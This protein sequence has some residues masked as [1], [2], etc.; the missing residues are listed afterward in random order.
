MSD[1]VSIKDLRQ[2][3]QNYIYKNNLDINKDSLINK[4]NGE[5]ATLLSNTGTSDIS[6]LYNTGRMRNKYTNIVIGSTIAGAG[7]A[8]AGEKLT[9]HNVYMNAHKQY[10]SQLEEAN[11]IIKQYNESCQQK[12]P[13]L[14]NETLKRVRTDIEKDAKYTAQQREGILKTIDDALKERGDIAKRAEVAE[15]TNKQQVANRLRELHKPPFLLRARNLIRNGSLLGIGLSIASALFF[16]YKA[17]TT[18]ASTERL[19]FQK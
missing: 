12:K 17:A 2:D 16:G 14:W 5:L 9:S 1:D 10:S 4:D 6:K 3:V 13:D 15:Q 11:K 7:I 8:Y 19:A 18:T